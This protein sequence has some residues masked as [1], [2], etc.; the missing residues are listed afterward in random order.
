MT[1]QQEKAYPRFRAQMA[2]VSK[3]SNLVWAKKNWS[4][5][6]QREATNNSK[7]T[8][9]NSFIKIVDSKKS[10][11]IVTLSFALWNIKDCFYMFSLFVYCMLA[12]I[13]LDMLGNWIGANGWIKWRNNK[14]LIVF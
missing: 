8:E 3:T 7:T 11:K 9:Q 13:L 12:M 10:F 1:C 6:L 4:K 2:K 5:Y 14:R